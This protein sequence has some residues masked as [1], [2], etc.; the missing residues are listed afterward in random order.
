MSISLPQWYWCV[1]KMNQFTIAVF[2]FQF[3]FCIFFQKSFQGV[4]TFKYMS[5]NEKII[6]F[7]LQKKSLICCFYIIYYTNE[8]TCA[9]TSKFILLKTCVFYSK[10]NLPKICSQQLSM[11]SESNVV[12]NCKFLSLINLKRGTC[13]NDWCPLLCA[14]WSWK[15]SQI[16][17]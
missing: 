13:V 2:N 12:S 3:N 15:T 16:G 7:T 4:L 10:K 14:Q 9:Y 8:V 6:I 1:L 11:T 5:L 17:S